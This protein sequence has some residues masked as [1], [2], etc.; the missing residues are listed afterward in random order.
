MAKQLAK[1][2]LRPVILTANPNYP[3]GRVYPGYS[4]WGR[5]REQYQ[6]FTIQRCPVYPSRDSS[7]L[8]RTA[9]YVSFACSS[10]IVGRRILAAAD[11]N[12]VYSSPAPAA[13]AA[14]TA[15]RMH[16]TPYVMWVQDLWPDTIFAT[17]FLRNS[18]ARRTAQT[19]VGAFTQAAYRN[20]SHVAVITPGMKQL[21][22]ERGVPAERITVVYNWVDEAVVRPVPDAGSLRRQLGLKEHDVVL[23]YAGGIGLAQQLTS[24]IEAMHLVRDLPG[25]HLVVVGE[26]PEKS[27]LEARANN[28]GLSNVTFLPRVGRESVVPLIAE[29]DVQV[30]SLAD[31]PL[32]DITLPSKTQNILACARPMIASLRGDLADIIAESG[33]GWAPDPENPKA[34]AHAIKQAHRVGRS[35]LRTMGGLGRRYYIDHM[36]ERSGGDALAA[37]VTEAA[38]S[39]QG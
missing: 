16:Q 4:A 2:G 10:T 15:R 14:I 32:F 5:T 31:H 8:R 23:M 21:L 33:A 7:A 12:F 17:G 37:I 38:R 11:V 30:V 3:T 25:L 1:R 35:G 24:W 9:T 26:G 39:D 27:K 6:G 36:S 22:I 28:L 34:I 19:A 29:S 20:A 18:V 13:A